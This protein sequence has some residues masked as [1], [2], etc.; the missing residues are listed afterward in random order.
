VETDIVGTAWADDRVPLVD[1]VTFGDGRMVLLSVEER[2][3]GEMGV[4]ALGETTV[5]SFLRFNPDRWAHITATCQLPSASGDLYIAGEGSYGSDG[6][7]ARVGGAAGELRYCVFL[8]SSNPFV[9]L[10]LNSQQTVLTATSNLGARWFMNV[11]G[12][13]EITTDAPSRPATAVKE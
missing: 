4:R 2:P 8:S 7:V 3:S 5:A 12:P 9:S 11:D 6:F 1:S 10:D 13:W